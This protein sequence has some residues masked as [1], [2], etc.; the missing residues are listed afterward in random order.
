MITASMRSASV[1]AT[2][3][4]DRHVRVRGGVIAA[5]AAIGLA[6]ER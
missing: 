2:E 5:R 1:A 4:V 3:S 6:H